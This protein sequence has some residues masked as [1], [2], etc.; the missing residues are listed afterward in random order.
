MRGTIIAAES[1]KASVKITETSKVVEIDD[2]QLTRSNLVNEIYASD[3]SEATFLN[4]ANLFETIRRRY[5]NFIIYT[6]CADTCVA[7]NPFK[8]LPVYAP[9]VVSAYASNKSENLP[10]HIFNVANRA[11]EGLL[12]NRENQSIVLTGECGS[13][14]TIINNKLLQYFARLTAGPSESLETATIDETLLQSVPLLEAFG[15]AKMNRNENSSRFGKL[16]RLHFNQG[17]VL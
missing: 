11:Y 9:Y 3:V 4:E 17:K 2:T 16:T 7:V 8:V 14:K 5:N 10:P 1:G 15:N 6:Q 12:R 13:G